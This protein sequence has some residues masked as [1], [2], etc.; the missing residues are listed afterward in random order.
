MKISKDKIREIEKAFICLKRHKAK[1]DVIPKGFFT[2]N[3]Y[4]E[5]KNV[6]RCTSERHLGQLF[7]LNKVE[8]KK[9][10]IKYAS[11]IK[12]VEHYRYI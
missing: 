10:K 11:G 4:S 12:S 1:E 8:V 9:F 5:I 7:R 2:K 3:E 6:S